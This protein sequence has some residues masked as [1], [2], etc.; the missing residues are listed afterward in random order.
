LLPAATGDGKLVLP[1]S[2]GAR[3]RL[4]MAATGGDELLLL[5][6]LARGRDGRVLP[7]SGQW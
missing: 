7:V 2:A 1:L 6:K 5:A 3:I 4:T